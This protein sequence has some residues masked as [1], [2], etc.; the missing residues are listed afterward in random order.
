[1]REVSVVS[2]AEIAV[3]QT[4]GKLRFGKN[5]VVAGVADLRVRVVTPDEAFSLYE[6][7]RVIW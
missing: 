5:D 3:E 7:L 4:R 1:V 6:G 2:L